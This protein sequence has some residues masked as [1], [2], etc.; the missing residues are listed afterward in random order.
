MTT[1]V[2]VMVAV[3]GLVWL[4]YR[5]PHRPR[6]WW[7]TRPI[8]ARPLVSAVDRQ[9]RHLQAGGLI[10]ETT[11]EATKA[12]LHTLLANGRT[13]DVENELR[14]GLDYAVQVRALA[15][16]GTADAGRVLENQLSRTLSRDPVEQSWYWVDVASGLR[17]LNRIDALPA[18]LKCADAAAELPQGVVLAA[19]AVAFPNYPSTLH[20]LSS[21]N[22]KSALR[23]LA[24]AARG[25]REGAIDPSV[26]VRAGIGDHLGAVSETAPAGADPWATA[27]VLEA[28][29]VFRRMGHWSKHIAP[30]ARPLAERQGVRLWTSVA[31]RAEWL[32]GAAQRLIGR[33]PSAPADEQGAML[34]CLEDLRADVVGLFPALPDRRVPWWTDAVKALTWAKSRTVGPV[35]AGYAATLLSSRKS[36]ARVITLLTAMR[37][38][39][40]AEVERVLVAAA[41]AA[42]PTVRRAA[43]ASLGWT[44]PFD[45]AAVVRV[46]RLG[47]IDT[48]PAVRRAAGGALARFGD[49]AALKDYADSL[50]ND[51]P[52]VRVAAALSAG[53]EGLTWLWPDLDTLADSPDAETAL[54]AT[55]A[56]ERL[57]E[58]VFGPLG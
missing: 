6:R 43:L 34:R 14:A 49:R 17:R 15:E 54:A 13:A 38:H 7:L 12:R 48:N 51:E 47:R 9:H 25:C 1:A 22:G 24:R 35:L 56:L 4:A 52:S 45:T 33:F 57:R 46:S 50:A 36:T 27:A 20:D 18:V 37:G 30:D 26:M 42:N 5:R 16:I 40:L 21:A 10:G 55:E 58:L 29:R 41:T 8:A 53:E 19:E 32:G 31:R 44:D 23:A 2:I 11:F 28:E 3:G 39:R